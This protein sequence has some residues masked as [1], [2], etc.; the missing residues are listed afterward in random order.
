MSFFAFYGRRWS[1]SLTL[2]ILGWL[3]LGL[4]IAPALGWGPFLWEE[5]SI[6][7]NAEEDKGSLIIVPPTSISRKGYIQRKTQFSHQSTTR[8]EG[9]NPETRRGQWQTRFT[10]LKM[11][12]YV[13]CNKPR[14]D[15][16]R[17][18]RPQSAISRCWLYCSPSPLVF[19]QLVLILLLLG[20]YRFLLRAKAW[21]LLLWLPWLFLFSPFL[22]YISY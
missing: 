9:K 12:D 8:H 14:S 20:G 3:F 18:P 5:P 17:M 2:R 11:A 19:S 6:G 16:Q 13:S 15:S 1:V 22:W 10:L 4:A 21:A 7:R